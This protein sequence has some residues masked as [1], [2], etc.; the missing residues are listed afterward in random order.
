VHCSGEDGAGG[1][2]ALLADKEAELENLQAALGELSYEVEA[3]G[4]ARA[5]LR[6]AKEQL[7]A[8]AAEKAAAAAASAAAA[9]RASE[10]EASLSELRSQLDAAKASQAVA[11]EEAAMLRANLDKVCV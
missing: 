7:E 11:A 8:A 1:L 9:A 6:S 5:E 3:A 4:R 2:A 10:A